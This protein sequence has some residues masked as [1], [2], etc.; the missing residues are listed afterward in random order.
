MLNIDEIL[1]STPKN[2]A[3][4]VNIG[5][6]SFSKLTHNSDYFSIPLGQTFGNQKL[7]LSLND[8]SCLLIAGMTGSGK[9]V[10][11]KSVMA[12]LAR[13]HTHDRIKFVIASPRPKEYK[14]IKSSY[15]LYDPTISSSNQLTQAFKRLDDE[16][17][18]RFKIFN[19][20]QV[21]NIQE[22]NKSSKKRMARILI[23]L[24]GYSEIMSKG[25]KVNRKVLEKSLLKILQMGRAVG[26]HIILTT[27]KLGAKYLTP[28]FQAN[29]FTQIA[30]K[31]ADKKDSKNI[32]YVNGAERLMGKGDALLSQSHPLSV[33]LRIQAPYVSD[34]ELNKI[35]S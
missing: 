25:S 1:N 17:E 18:A 21:R 28:F 8:E 6:F 27:Q 35:L 15:F 26:I 12:Y 20:V 16:L 10:Y 29:F 31:T 23:L 33:Y 3:Q 2:N 34:K 19:D 24:D 5:E 22:Y 13:Q 14:G 11:V 9:T 7:T 4:T 30:F 32:I